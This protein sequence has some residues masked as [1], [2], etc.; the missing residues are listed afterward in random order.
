MPALAIMTERSDLSAL[1]QGEDRLF[2]FLEPGGNLRIRW[3]EQAEIPDTLSFRQFHAPRE[4]SPS[5]WGA[6]DIAG[7]W[8]PARSRVLAPRMIENLPPAR[9]PAAPEASNRAEWEKLCAAAQALLDQGSTQKLVPAR[10]TSFALTREEHAEILAAV[11]PRLFAPAVENAYRFVIKSRG[12]VFFGAT[13]ELLFHREKGEIKV[14]AIAGTQPLIPG[15][16]VTELSRELLSSQKDRIEHQWVVSGILESLRA[17]GLNPKAPA[18]PVVIQ[19]PRLLHLYT[20]ITAHDPGTFTGERLL[21]ALH[22][23][24][25]IGGHP[26]ARAAHFLYEN[27]PFDRGLFSAPL[28]F[29]SG[30]KEICLVAIRSALLNPERLHFFAGAGF[31]NGSTAEGEWRETE[32]KMHVMQTMLFGEAP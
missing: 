10:E 16:S 11:G 21:S 26:R 18:E 3:G 32:K 27:E 1:L 14:P 13:P 25:A 12:S 20:P 24:P 22:P 5:A 30:G 29:R 8:A 6:F 15:A 23:T 19:V 2:G 17:V 28:L 31:V 4:K 9:R 7:Q